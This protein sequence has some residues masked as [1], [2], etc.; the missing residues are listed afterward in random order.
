MQAPMGDEEMPPPDE[1]S[2]DGSMQAT[3]EEQEL[4]D[5]IVKNAMKL[6]YG[7]ARQKVLQMLENDDPVEALAQTAVTI[8]GRVYESAEE[9]GVE[10]PGE[11]AMNA[12]SEIMEQLA[13]YAGEAGIH[14]YSED[15]LEGA[16]FRALDQFRLMREQ[17]GKVDKG[18]MMQD[19]E[20]IKQADQDGT[21]ERDL[22]GMA[23]AAPDNDNEGEPT[24][25]DPEADPEDEDEGE[26][27][28]PKRGL[29]VSRGK[30]GGDE[31]KAAP[32]GEAAKGDK[33]SA[34]GFA[35]SEGG[36]EK[37]RSGVKAPGFAHTAKR[38]R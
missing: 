36:M 27:A 17:Q 19:L 2:E 30:V 22:M 4:S 7:D 6:M 28:P 15:E 9:N 5:K 26:E 3:P 8:F 11:V 31:S 21:L 35:S 10:I 14:D 18:V 32:K 25:E 34:P 13:D 29:G 23:Q 12:G 38:G 20:A 37:G 16:W 24:E 33:G 1:M